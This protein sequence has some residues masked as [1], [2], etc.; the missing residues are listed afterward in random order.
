M[1]SQT[2]TI[3]YQ[4]IPDGTITDNINSQTFT[5][6]LNEVSEDNISD[7]IQFYTISSGADGDSAYDIAVDN[8]FV[9]TEEQWLASLKGDKGDKGDT[10]NTGATGTN[11]YTPIKGVDYFDGATGA[12]GDTGNDGYTPI[13]GIDQFD[14]TNGID[15]TDGT[16]G[17]GIPI[18]GTTG[19]VLAKKTNTDYD[20]EWITSSAG[21]VTSFNSR[22][23]IVLPVSG[24]YTADKITETTTLKFF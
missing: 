11:G 13:K 4:D 1:S 3:A 19:Q 22:T 15:G 10:G 6:T 2:I 7:L 9:G 23:G 8:G 18:G 21:G 17:V 16:D 5:V 14:G 24:D 20:T 12:K